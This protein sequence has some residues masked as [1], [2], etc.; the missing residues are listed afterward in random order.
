MPLPCL[1]EEILDPRDQMLHATGEFRRHIPHRVHELDLT[2]AQP[3][4]TSGRGFADVPAV[5]AREPLLAGVLHGGCRVAGGGASA[6]G[7]GGAPAGAR[8]AVGLLAGV[9][10]AS[11]PVPG[12]AARPP[13]FACRV[14]GGGGIGAGALRRQVVGL[15]PALHAG[16][17]IWV[18]GHHGLGPGRAPCAGGRAGPRRGVYT[19]LLAHLGDS[20]LPV[21]LGREVARWE[22]RCGGGLVAE[23]LGTQR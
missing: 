17:V 23:A 3:Q 9:I 7:G 14:R 1:V 11:Q 22:R 13:A 10:P 12:G 19:Q 8:A 15:L 18:E 2:H 21:R 5:G 6:L 16:G 4:T 20:V